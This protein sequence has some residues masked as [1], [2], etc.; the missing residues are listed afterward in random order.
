MF[1]SCSQFI[2]NYT[3]EESLEKMR[4]LKIRVRAVLPKLDEVGKSKPAVEKNLVNY[5]VT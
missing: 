4:V 3:T 5:V 2:S 1:S